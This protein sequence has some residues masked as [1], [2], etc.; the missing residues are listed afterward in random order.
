MIEQHAIDAAIES[1]MQTM[2]ANCH[3]RFC[4][5]IWATSKGAETFLGFNF[6]TRAQ[7]GAVAN[8]AGF[9]RTCVAIAGE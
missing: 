2:L 1:A 3:K 7:I 6:D 9:T 5:R 4:A 8:D